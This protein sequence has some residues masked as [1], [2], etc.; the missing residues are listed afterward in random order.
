MRANMSGLLPAV[1]S[2]EFAEYRPQRGYGDEKVVR[3]EA[4]DQADVVADAWLQTELATEVPEADYFADE[5]AAEWD[6]R[7]EREQG[8]QNRQL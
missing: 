5:H 6:E 2:A 8:K 1:D 3:D 7:Q 4:D